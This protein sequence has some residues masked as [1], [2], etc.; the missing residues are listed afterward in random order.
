MGSIRSRLG[1][2]VLLFPAALSRLGV[3]DRRKGEEAFDLAV[4][5]MVSGGL[6]V[7]LRIADF[8]MVGIALGDAAIAALELGFQYFFIGFGLSLAVT[9][10]TISVVSRYEGAGRHAAADFAMKQSLWLALAISAPLTFAS[11]YYPRP[12]IDLLTDDPRT[13]ALGAAYLQVVMLSLPFR[14]WSMVASRALAGSGDTRTPMYVRVLTLP[15][16]VVL[17]ALLIFGLL[18]FPRLGISARPSEPRLRTRS[19]G[20]SFSA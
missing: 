1:E 20:R 14:F 3:V 11:W 10:G 5:V 7:L 16:N 2:A 6:R 4:P 19:R 8:L 12:L 18:G 17:N 13:I 15:A 9:S